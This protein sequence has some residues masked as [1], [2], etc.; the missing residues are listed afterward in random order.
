MLCF[1]LSS[2]VVSLILDGLTGVLQDKLKVYKVS[3]LHMM[4]A[5]NVFAPIYLAVGK[6]QLK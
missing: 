2:Q 1:S 5:M 3:G 4:F 6:I